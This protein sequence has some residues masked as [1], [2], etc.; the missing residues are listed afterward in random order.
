MNTNLHT[1]LFC[2]IKKTV[3]SWI[4][5]DKLRSG[6]HG[7]YKFFNLAGKLLQNVASFSSVCQ[8]LFPWYRNAMM[9]IFNGVSFERQVWYIDFKNNG[10]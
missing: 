4:T 2:H 8:I 6:K 9:I 7:F 3:F 10:V 5:L 1:K